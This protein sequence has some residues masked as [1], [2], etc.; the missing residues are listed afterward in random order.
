VMPALHQLSPAKLILVIHGGQSTD[1]ERDKTKEHLDK[2]AGLYG[3]ILEIKT[4]KA[5]AYDPVATAA[6]IAAI[7]EAERKNG[8][9]VIVN[10]T[11]GR[12]ILGLGVLFGAY[13]RIDQVER[14]VYGA[15]FDPRLIDLPKM[16]FNMGNTKIRMLEARRKNP[17]QSVSEAAEKVGVTPAMAYVHLRELK[18]MGYV[19][20]DYEVTSAGRLAL[21]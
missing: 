9:R 2:L 17:K 20:D 19:N 16:S 6:K 18:A 11:G 14:I 21:L 1:T 3:K 15:D 4:E 10:I 13:A 8:C 12:K 7:I 5:D